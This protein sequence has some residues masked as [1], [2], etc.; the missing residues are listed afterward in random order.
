LTKTDIITAHRP[1]RPDKDADFTS[2]CHILLAPLFDIASME[3]SEF[4]PALMRSLADALPAT[5]RDIT[6]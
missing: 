5:T 2:A 4:S 1:V 6:Q 3:A